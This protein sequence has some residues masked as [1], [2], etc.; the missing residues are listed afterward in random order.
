MKN[1]YWSYNE[2]IDASDKD[3][4]RI[5]KYEID[6]FRETC[7]RL[8]STPKPTTKVEQSE[9]NLLVES[10]AI[11]ARIL[12][13]FFYNDLFLCKNKKGF[14][15]RNPNDI[16]AQDFMPQGTDWIRARPELTQTLYDARE[17][18]NK[19]LAHL[20]LWRIKL[21]RDGKK[22]WDVSKISKDLENVIEK[23]GEIF[24]NQ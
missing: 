8:T 13:D 21:E 18:A 12:V 2:L 5:L 10:L 15:R 11:H 14:D 20:N 9:Y 16:I 24:D 7:S 17:K 22:G 1:N 23:F 6:M 19:Q 4:E 3:K